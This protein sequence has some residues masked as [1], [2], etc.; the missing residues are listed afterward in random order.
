MEGVLEVLAKL[1]IQDLTAIGVVVMVI[2]VCLPCF[3]C[4]VTATG[5]GPRRAQSACSHILRSVKRPTRFDYHQIEPRLFLGSLPRT[6]ED[7]EML[8]AQGVG[9][10]VTLN[11]VWEMA[12]ST[13][14]VRD[15]CGLDH[16]HLPTPD[17]FAP[18]DESIEAAVQFITERTA[19]GIGVYVHCNGGKGR[20]AV[21]VICYLVSIHDMTPEDAFDLVAT[22][23]TVAR[24][25]GSCGLHKQ[26]RAV[27]RFARNRKR[28]PQ[29][30]FEA[31]REDPAIANSLDRPSDNALDTPPDLVVKVAQDEEAKGPPP[32]PP[33]CA[34]PWAPEH[35]ESLLPEGGPAVLGEP[36]AAPAGS[37]TEPRAEL[38]AEPRAEPGAENLVLSSNKLAALKVDGGS[39]QGDGPTRMTSSAGEWQDGYEVPGYDE[40]ARYESDSQSSEEEPPLLE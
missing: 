33:P 38:P 2:C 36:P 27:K 20:S 32:L 17:F 34:A 10:V 29:A 24:L 25:R 5:V 23:R 30:P 13:R 12:L 26:W 35:P 6:L 8:K 40:D 3:L 1:S 14:F 7:L 4:F 11:E 21:C 19:K 28:M 37:R 22:K 31:F 16:L 18:S 39:V 9:A 15:E